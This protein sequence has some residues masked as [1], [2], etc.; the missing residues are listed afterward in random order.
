MTQTFLVPVTLPPSSWILVNT[1]LHAKVPCRGVAPGLA[2]W[3]V[4]QGT[5]VRTIQREGHREEVSDL[6][7]AKKVTCQ[8]APKGETQ[9]GPGC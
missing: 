5:E 6:H 9:A 2:G 3:G 7:K 4:G 1:V 8:Q